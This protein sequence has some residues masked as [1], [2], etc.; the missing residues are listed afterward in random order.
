M[1][2]SFTIDK[3][4]ALALGLNPQINRAAY[5]HSFTFFDSKKEFL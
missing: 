4:D 5:F 1:L 2:Q 3:V